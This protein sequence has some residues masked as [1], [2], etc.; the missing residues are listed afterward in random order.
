M[1]KRIVMFLAA[2]M[3]VVCAQADTYTWTDPATGY[4]WKYDI[5]GDEVVIGSSG[6]H[7]DLC[8]SP[9]PTGALT[10]PATIGGKMVK[11]IGDYAFRDCSGLTSV[12]I[13]NG[14]TS[15]GEYAF[16]DCSGLTSVTIP[17]SV[18]RI[19][20][21]AFSGCSSLTSVTIPNSVTSVGH[22][23][24]DDTPFYN[25]QSD[26]LVI[27]GKILYAMK[28]S[29]PASVTIPNGVAIIG[30]GAFSG[31]GGLTSITIPS[32]VTCIGDSAFSGCSGLTSITIPSSVKRIEYG[33]FEDCSGLTSVTIPSGVT[34]IGSWAFGCC[35]RLANVIINGSNTFVGGCAFACCTNLT[36][37]TIPIGLKGI[38]PNAF[39]CDDYGLEEQ[40]P[41]AFRLEA[42]KAVAASK[43][44]SGDLS[45]ETPNP[46]YNLTQAQEDR[47]IASM[48]INA[49]TALSNFTLSNGKVYDTVIRI[50]N[51]S[52]NDVRVTLPSG[53]EYETVKGANPLT[54]PANSKNILTITRTTDNVFLVSRRELETVR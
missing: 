6:C 9:N 7:G 44:L 54:I 29:C 26:G 30:D 19:E 38:S 43:L 18:K 45:L 53:Y 50:V 22:G 34:E 42:A 24:F 14:V 36:D 4:T 37:V 48:T 32:S 40:T 11:S 27:F 17:D 13:P 33:A 21:G 35:E 12:T 52:A 3:A 15:I 25:N 16:R 31:C 23:A 20:Y 39:W 5:N 47:A 41:F 46:R 8:I 49:D 10:I 2:A 28:G 51:T 1:K